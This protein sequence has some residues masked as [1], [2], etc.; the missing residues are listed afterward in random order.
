MEFT[1]FFFFLIID[2]LSFFTVSSAFC[3]VFR[4]AYE[5]YFVIFSFRNAVSDAFF[6]H[7]T[8]Q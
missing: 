7:K 4:T 2:F 6:L 1:S 5:R 3:A 8:P